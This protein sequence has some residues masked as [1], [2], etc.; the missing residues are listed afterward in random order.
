MTND[1]VE[2][3]R[4]FSRHMEEY[5]Q[6]RTVLKYTMD[7]SGACDLISITQDSRICVWNI[8]KYALRLWNGHAK[9][10]DLA[11]ICHYAE[12]AWTLNEGKVV[13]DDKKEESE[14]EEP[15]EE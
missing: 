11:K 15:G 13:R 14:D 8:L 2:N 12:M 3:W 9:D 7:E 10:H 5:I 6:E 4:R 1:R